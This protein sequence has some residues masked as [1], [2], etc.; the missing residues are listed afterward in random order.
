MAPRYRQT[1]TEK[2]SLPGRGGWPSRKPWAPRDWLNICGKGGAS[3]LGVETSCRALRQ[4]WEDDGESKSDR[5]EFVRRKKKKI[6]TCQCRDSQ[7]GWRIEG[8]D[9]GS[10]DVLTAVETVQ[11][12]GRFSSCSQRAGEKRIKGKKKHVAISCLF[13]N[14]EKND[15]FYII[16]H[17]SWSLTQSH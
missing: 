17:L 13:K 16:H 7:R 12:S 2:H 6:V 11:R 14:V 4:W 8:S 15:F 1:K 5:W 10:Q 3:L 9:V